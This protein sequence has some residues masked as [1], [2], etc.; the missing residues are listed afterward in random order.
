MHSI[1][2]QPLHLDSLLRISATLL[3]LRRN[4][5]VVKRIHARN[6]VAGQTHSPRPVSLLLQSRSSAEL[7]N[8]GN[9]G[10]GQVVEQHVEG[11]AK[12]ATDGQVFDDRV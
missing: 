10:V 12:L 6:N 1:L 4:A 11:I 8:A 7:L 2:G 3:L 5:Q 9:V